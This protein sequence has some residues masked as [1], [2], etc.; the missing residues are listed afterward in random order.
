M[1]RV[2]FLVVVFLVAATPAFAAG[3]SCT[4]FDD[5][6]RPASN[7]NAGDKIIVRGAS[8]APNSLVLVTFQQGTRTAEISHL[9]TND[10]GAFATDPSSSRL[11]ASV[12]RGPA[13]IQ[14]L[15]GSGAASC[16]IRLVSAQ[17][18]RAGGLSRT[19][20]LTWGIVLLL[21]FFGLVFA[22]IRRW[23]AD[24]VSQQIDAIPWEKPAAATLDADDEDEEQMADAPLELVE[25]PRDDRPVLEAY[26]DDDVSAPSDAVTRLR[27]EV[28]SWKVR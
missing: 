16:E 28:R 7:F 14:V 11:P 4:T 25:V 26:V 20:Y 6:N 9:K 17:S 1:R 12:E 19:F 10:L 23:Q 22:T 2:L 27:R 24:R 15:Q 5:G 8:Y 18:S 21:C 13:T 3:P